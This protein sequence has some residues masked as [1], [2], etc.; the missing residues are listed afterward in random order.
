MELFSL[1]RV[2][3]SSSIVFCEHLIQLSAYHFLLSYSR[4]SQCVTSIFFRQ[5]NLNWPTC[6]SGLKSNVNLAAKT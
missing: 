3:S 1:S 2:L 5:W 6:L 4:Q